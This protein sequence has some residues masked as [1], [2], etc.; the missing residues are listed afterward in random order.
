MASVQTDDGANGMRSDFEKAAAHLLPYDPVAR[1]RA[2]GTKQPAANISDT[3]GIHGANA[4]AIEVS[5][6]TSK[7]GKISI[8]KTGVHLRYHSTPNIESYP[9]HKRENFLNG[10]IKTQKRR[11]NLTTKS[12][13]PSL[14]R[15]LLQ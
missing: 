3:W 4:S 5:E 12:E 14:E 9:Q 8:G 6:A 11:R 15:Y 10:K 7:D 2:A 1:K 13:R